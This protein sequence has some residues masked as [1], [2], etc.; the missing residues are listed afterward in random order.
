MTER[1]E[2]ALADAKSAL[3]LSNRVPNQALDLANKALSFANSDDTETNAYAYAA[4][5]S[6][7]ASLGRHDE[8]LRHINE[9]QMLAFESRLTYVTARIHQARGWTAYCQGNSVL[10][11]ADWQIAFDHFQ[12]IRDLRGTAWIL[13]HYAANYSTLGLIDHS[14]RCQISALE[15]VRMMSDFDTLIELKVSLAQ[16]YVSKAWQ[17]TFIGDRGFSL[18]D[19][20]I[21]TAI[22]LKVLEHNLEDFA[23]SIVEQAFQGLGEALIIQGRPEEAL[24][25]LHIALGASLRSGHY[26]SEA[27]I[28]GSLGYAYHLCGDA[29]NASKYL[30]QAIDH[31]PEA[32]PTRDRALIHLWNSVVVEASGNA[33]TALDELRKSVELDQQDQQVRMERWAKV[34]DMTL[35]IGGALVSI[36]SIAERENTWIFEESQIKEHEERAQKFLKDDSLTGVLHRNEAFDLTRTRD[37]QFAAVYEVVNLTAINQKFERKIGD[38]VLRNVASVLHATVSEDSVVGRFSGTEFFVSMKGDCFDEVLT[39]LTNFPWLAIEP[40]LN[41]RIACRRVNPKQPQLLAA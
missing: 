40:E 24:P 19:A 23:P 4:L 10:A 7:Y 6:C 29:I 8:A 39:T 5:G 32:T 12:Q 13:M 41:V 35:G 33:K 22:L 36:E 25:N 3:E 2:Q 21:A 14:I 34:H 26:S 16:S 38:E 9:A 20:Q 27:K 30:A 28:Q 17:R 15:M 31:A 11:F 18:F 1:Q 37:H